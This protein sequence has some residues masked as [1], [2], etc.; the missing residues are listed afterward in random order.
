VIRKPL[1]LVLL[2][3]LFVILL[4]GCSP[5]SAS[6]PAKNSQIINNGSS[7]GQTFTDRKDGLSGVSVLLGSSLYPSN[8]SLFFSL[9]TSPQ[10]D[11]NIATARLPI[12][13]VDHQGYYNFDFP[14]IEPSGGS[15]WI[16]LEL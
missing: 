1:R 14:P 4:A 5:S 10:S 12:S 16:S 15:T 8:G 7:F 3:F 13:E 2:L 11:E 6:I 9:R